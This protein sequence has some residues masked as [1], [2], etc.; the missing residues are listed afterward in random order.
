MSGIRIYC[1]SGNDEK[2]KLLFDLYDGDHDGFL[3]KRDILCM[4]LPFRQEYY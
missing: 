3:E 1:K 4:V 2:I